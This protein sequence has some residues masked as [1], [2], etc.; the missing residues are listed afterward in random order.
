MP[1]GGHAPL[2]TIPPGQD[3]AGT[4]A[5]F[6]LQQYQNDPLKLADIRLFLPTRRSCRV[7]RDA[8]LRQS[9][10]NA[11]LL[12]RM[13][14]LGDVEG[15]ELSLRIA[16]LGIEKS[17]ISALPQPIS[18][19]RRQIILARLLQQRA[20]YAGKPGQALTLAA[21]LGRLIDHIHTENRDIAELPGLVPPDL[22][23][24]WQLTLD[25]L[26]ILSAAWP[27]ILKEMGLIDASDYRNRMLVLLTRHWQ[28]H[29][30]G[31]P[32]IAAGSTG[33]IPATANLLKT[34]AGL[35]QGMVI[36]P[37]LDQGMDAKS[38][39]AMD[40][41]HPQ[42]TMRNLLQHIGSSR[43][44][45]Q[46]IGSGAKGPDR[47]LLA[48][49]MMRPA[50]TTDN[51]R[52][53]QKN[54]ERL[55]P[56]LSGLQR[57]D[58]ATAEDEAQLIALMLR[59]VQH[60]PPKTAALVTFDRAL[61]RRVA[62]HCARWGLVLDD[63]AGTKL[64][65]AKTGAFMLL[66]AE[67]C[68]SGL[69][70]VGLLSLL[71]HELAMCGLPPGESHR[72]ARRLERRSLRGPRPG[73][74]LSG[75]IE[76]CPDMEAYIRQIGA[77]L[78]P[79]LDLAS[80]DHTF[81][82]FLESHIAVLE[83]LASTPTQPGAA[84]LWQGDDGEAAAKFLM[85][86]RDHADS[87]PATTMTGYIAM[88][89]ALMEA[90]SVRP[91]WGT[92]P[93]L[94]IMGPLEA[95]MI[96]A[97]LVILGGLNEGSWPPAPPTDPWMSRP[98]RT[99]FGLPGPERGIGLSAHDFVQGFSAPNVVITRALR[100]GSS[101]TLPSR[102]LE[103]LETVLKA[104]GL[105]LPETDW[106]ERSLRYN[107]IEGPPCPATR[108]APVP[109]VEKRPERLSVTEIETWM[110]DPYAVYAKHILSVKPLDEIDKTLEFSDQGTL[111]HDALEIFVKQYP[112]TL[113][114]NAYDVLRTIG[115]TLL[116]E[117]VSNIRNRHFWGIRFDQAAAWFV[118]YEQD[119]RTQAR[120]I[121]TETKGEMP[122]RSPVLGGTFT[123]RAK[124]DRFDR[125]VDGSGITV[126]DY[127]S[128]GIPAKA[129][130]ELGLSP[131][132]PLEA[133]MIKTGA[134]PGIAANDRIAGL[135]Y[136]KLGGSGGGKASTITGPDPASLADQAFD[137]LQNLVETFG[138][139]DTPYY[140]QPRASHR[141]RFSDYT[142]LARVQEWSVVDDSENGG[143]E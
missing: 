45:V 72:S 111:F 117:R 65:A 9:E 7:V 71:K 104:V 92:H 13:Q 67:C 139:P 4:L 12:P 127:K 69:A 105:T 96:Q 55:I 6:L 48:T 8:F 112:D 86:L 34:I 75:L 37:G 42:A 141:P 68:A 118:R 53:L 134:F 24:H 108:P 50:G 85:D 97:D 124:A 38:W 47:S 25:F 132:L 44:Q 125:M 54:P 30:P 60:T 110:R 41:T 62:A 100:S 23:A 98:M 10:G 120:P 131:Q 122:V 2:L 138:R 128:G 95:R 121:A 56:A 90:V 80:G 115:H 126:I 27:A 64:P 36:L 83:A 70:P 21:E 123:L 78:Q 142:H 89:Q 22:A 35:P 137:G 52:N 102:W 43:S 11:L 32:V 101:P 74:G 61:A 107:A 82:A 17:Q 81:A 46:A 79:L 19:L 106:L 135:S 26:N 15:E 116:D 31:E 99:S 103:R 40:D 76:A 39:D 93:R 88:L 33:S 73:T 3:F 129:D 91:N 130:M 51:W 94:S 136:W 143:S 109:P 113:P 140:S 87:L 18:M 57:I 14:P 119:W 29:P 114:D 59:Q 77:I 20:D 66:A 84:V 1:L 16:A 28:D 58:C 49:E 63:T 133:A 5:A